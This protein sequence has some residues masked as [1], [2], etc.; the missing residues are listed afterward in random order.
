LQ[1]ELGERQNGEKVNDVKIPKWA[2]SLD[3]FINKNIQ[4]LES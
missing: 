1:L 3:K 2:E 4:A